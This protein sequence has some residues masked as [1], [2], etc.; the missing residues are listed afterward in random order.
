[1]RVAKYMIQDELNGVVGRTIL[2]DFEREIP[3]MVNV[4]TKKGGVR[5]VKEIVTDDEFQENLRAAKRLSNEYGYF[6]E[7]KKKSGIKGNLEFDVWVNGVEKWEFKSLKALSSRSTTKDVTK[8]LNQARNYY[9]NIK[10]GGDIMRVAKPLSDNYNQINGTII[11]D[12]Q[13]T[14]RKITPDKWKTKDE[15]FSLLTKQP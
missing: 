8:G 4:K 7:M 14:R 10:E 1:M 13:G 2:K 15:L 9:I 11:I 3:G 12:H 6:I 5:Y